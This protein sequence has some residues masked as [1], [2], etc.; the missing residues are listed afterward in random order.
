VLLLGAT[1]VLIGIRFWLTSRE[2]DEEV[3]TA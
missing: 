1:I 3:G 2:R